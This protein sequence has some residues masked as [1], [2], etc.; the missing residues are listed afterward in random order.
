MPSALYQDLFGLLLVLLSR[1]LYFQFFSDIG[2]VAE[3]GTWRAHV[4]IDGRWALWDLRHRAIDLLVRD[5]REQV[6][7]DVDAGALL[8]SDSTVYHGADGMSV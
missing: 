8:S 1:F 6:A 3:I 2:D 4:V 5:G 7:D